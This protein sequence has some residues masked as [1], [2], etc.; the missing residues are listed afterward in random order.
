MAS[1]HIILACLSTSKFNAVAITFATRY[2]CLL[3]YPR[4]P[5]LRGT[6]GPCVQ[7]N[8]KLRM[9]SWLKR[10]KTSPQSQLQ[11]PNQRPNAHHRPELHLDIPGQAP[12]LRN[13]RSTGNLKL[14]PPPPD[15]F[16]SNTNSVTGIHANLSSCALQFSPVS[17]PVTASIATPSQFTFARPQFDPSDPLAKVKAAALATSHRRN[18]LDQSTLSQDEIWVQKGIT[19][20]EQNRLQEATE[21]WRKAADVG[22]PNGM[23]LFG[24]SLRHGWGCR[25]DPNRAF[26][27]LQR[28]AESAV[29]QLNPNPS[30][31]NADMRKAARGELVAAIFELGMCFRHG[32]GVPKAKHTAV[33]YFEIAANLGDVDAMNELGYCF[34][35][36]E[37]VKKDKRKAAAWYRRA[38]KFGAPGSVGN[39]WIWKEKYDLATIS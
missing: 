18:L 12:T 26:L 39:A 10:S 30:Q 25:P 27:Y 38:V 9:L 24:I 36:G 37:G 23:L 8:L 14:K 15:F 5:S 17:T 4:N 22:N 11:P 34:L 32:W 20:H 19:L 16:S 1:W 31:N 2:S 6:N 13:V 33:Y 21:M 29:D 35:N 3:R 7:L 28:A